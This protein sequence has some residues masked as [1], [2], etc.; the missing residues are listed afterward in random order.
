MGCFHFLADCGCT[1]LL[2]SLT[3]T[4]KKMAGQTWHTNEYQA[5]PNLNLQAQVQPG[6]NLQEKFSE[7]ETCEEFY[8]IKRINIAPAFAQFPHNEW[9]LLLEP[10]T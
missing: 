7:V 5:W 2:F 4:K 10:L 3:H 9:Y 6:L 8:F 1:L